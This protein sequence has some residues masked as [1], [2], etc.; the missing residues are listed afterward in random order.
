MVKAIKKAIKFAIKHTLGTKLKARNVV[1]AL[2]SPAEN[3]A[4]PRTM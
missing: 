3:M 4:S 1:V 2:I